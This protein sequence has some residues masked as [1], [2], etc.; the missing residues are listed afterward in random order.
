M[1]LGALIPQQVFAL[2]MD[3]Y[4]YGGF[5][6][7]RDAFTRVALLFSDNNYLGYFAG[8]AVLGILLGGSI[9]AAR[10]LAG[11][12]AG[13]P[14]RWFMSVLVG[15]A[16]LKALVIPTG[17]V[18][19]YDSL[20][21]RSQDVDD[22][23][24][25]VVLVAGMLNKVER[26]I[27]A[28]VDNNSAYPYGE[29]A[30]GIRFELLYNASTQVAD[31]QDSYI[32]KTLSSY[33]I[34]CGLTAM[35][36]NGVAA[37]INDLKRNTYK[38]T[39]ELAKYAVK[40]NFALYYDAD[41]KNG[42][43]ATC[44]D[45]WQ[46]LETQLISTST[47]Y[48]GAIKEICAKS[49][50][51]PAHAA[52]LDKCKDLIERGHELAGAASGTYTASEFFANS[53]IANV[54][55]RAVADKDP[56]LAQQAIANRNLIVQGVG[57]ANT[58]NEWLPQ[59]RA[60]VLGLVLSMVPLLALFIVTP[61]MGQ[62]LL[63]LVSLLA[64]VTLWGISDA[65]TH[66]MAMDQATAYATKLA[67]SKEGLESMYLFP[68]ATLKAMAIFGKIRSMGIMVATVLS[69]ALFK[70]GGHAISNVAQSMAG[71]VESAGSKAAMQTMTHE[72]RAGLVNEMV[73]AN[74][75]AA[76]MGHF[77]MEKLSNAATFQRASQT[78]E[79][80]TQ[81]HAL[82]GGAIASGVETGAQHGGSAAGSTLS[83]RRMA[84]QL[85]MSP[86]ELTQTVSQ[87]RQYEHTHDALGLKNIQEKLGNGSQEDGA[88]F[89]AMVS[90][91]E[92]MTRA[93]NVN[94]M[95]TA[96]RDKYAQQNP[97]S[98][99]SEDDA[100]RTLAKYQSADTIGDIL[101]TSGNVQTKLDF[102]HDTKMMSIKQLSETKKFMDENGLGLDD[103]AYAR[104]KLEGTSGV[105]QVTA[106]DQMSDKQVGGLMMASRFD[107][108]NRGIDGNVLDKMYQEYG[109]NPKA[110][111]KTIAE[112]HRGAE[113]A[114]ALLF[115]KAAAI[116]NS[117]DD[118]VATSIS[119]KGGHR[120]MSFR[121]EDAPAVI[122]A[123]ESSG[124]PVSREVAN[125]ARQG[126]LASLSFAPG[127]HGET[128]IVAGSIR[129]GINAEVDNTAT[130]RHGYHAFDN[131]EIE[132]IALR[133]VRDTDWAA[134]HQIAANDDTRKLAI[135]KNIGN[136]VE[137]FVHV[138][139]T[140]SGS[141]TE[142][143]QTEW[144]YGAKSPSGLPG[145]G[146]DGPPSKTKTR[147]GGK[148]GIGGYEIA[149]ELA[150]RILDVHGGRSGYDQNQTQD[151][152]ELSFGRPAT[153]GRMI[154][155]E[156]DKFAHNYATEHQTNG[157]YE[158]LKRQKFG[159]WME[160]FVENS[161]DW[162]NTKAMEQFNKSDKGKDI[163]TGLPKQ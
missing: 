63:L 131:F 89:L 151:G 128:E 22:V 2:E 155:D 51:D 28:V 85:G 37:N 10:G 24:D 29:E 149:A 43:T 122:K 50:I 160:A 93:E 129:G 124:T 104:G 105:G 158:D 33:F 126:G 111:M 152:A 47:S 134:D 96:I 139:A 143:E 77:G 121:P 56:E 123:L 75:T 42:A 83:T 118:P 40:N 67:S 86:S 21:N 25:I 115:T 95:A 116:L 82:G 53:Y 39:D 19:I 3:Y 16:L 20:S 66:Q 150:A 154:W 59:I 52:S 68:D 135:Q 8:F 130:E 18:W 127:R 125:L 94:Q 132:P 163:V 79:L 102:L 140:S 114:E 49:N 162:L 146:H 12:G 137:Q 108:M 35:N 120:Q 58:A 57:M 9:T 44:S 65:L 26:G 31:L 45:I 144:G 38:L 27:I 148:A 54:I 159:E 13:A 11:Q 88:Q 145:G 141:M 112:Q 74:A 136:Y 92:R 55:D 6:V 32:T 48:D 69:G 76:S 4:T 30:G 117:K 23:P 70:F 99:M 106:L 103:L 61:L 7:T 153:V 17:K 60:V 110:V 78:Q 100:F 34:E 41:N 133:R 14:L 73:S 157:N 91:T 71:H 107:L 113:F 46:G 101:A 36:T 161:P 90:S 98:Q 1:L 72:G 62:A 80:L 64:W 84:A 97:G 81:M 5:E 156:A 147:G 15:V 142:S 119:L 138:G 87:A 109:N